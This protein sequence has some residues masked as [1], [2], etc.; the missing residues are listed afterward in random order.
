VSVE[1]SLGS[2]LFSGVCE[3]GLEV[4]KEVGVSVFNIVL[5]GVKLFYSLK[6]CFY[7][8]VNFG[9]FDKCEGN[10]NVSDWGFEARD[11]LVCHHIEP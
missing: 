1:G 2:F 8:S 6:H 5:N 9:S 7:P 10:G 3:L 11:F 4:V